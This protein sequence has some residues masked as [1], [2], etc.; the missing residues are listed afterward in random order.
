MQPTIK[1]TNWGHLFYTLNPRVARQPSRTEAQVYVRKPISDKPMRWW[2]VM[3]NYKGSSLYFYRL[4]KASVSQQRYRSFPYRQS[5]RSCGRDHN[6]C[7]SVE[8][9][10]GLGQEDR[11]IVMKYSA[12]LF[13][14]PS[15]R[16]RGYSCF[17]Y[18]E[19]QAYLRQGAINRQAI[20]IGVLHS[21]LAIVKA[22]L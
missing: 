11:S 6:N 2:A 16:K 9:S 3:Q 17:K 14:T 13:R 4:F 8:S 1:I 19:N 5:I 10:Q 21:L 12:K 22:S 18:I 7:W 20:L 15:V